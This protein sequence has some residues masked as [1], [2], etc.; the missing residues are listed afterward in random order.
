MQ[1]ERQVKKE[2]LWKEEEILKYLSDQNLFR[3][4]ECEMRD[5]SKGR[6]LR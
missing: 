6:L 2:G 4:S 1:D 5:N 3:Y